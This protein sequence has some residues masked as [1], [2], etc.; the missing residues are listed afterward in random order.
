[1]AVS[2]ESKSKQKKLIQKPEQDQSKIK[3]FFLFFR[4]VEDEEAISQL[5]IQ[6]VR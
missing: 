4:I 3:Y 1:M 2:C 6:E 5:C